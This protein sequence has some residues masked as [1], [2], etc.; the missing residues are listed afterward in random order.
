VSG[1]ERLTVANGLTALRVLLGGGLLYTILIGYERAALAILALGLLTELDGTVA[2]ATNTATE[3]GEQFDSAADAIFIGCGLLALV[4]IGKLAVLE[5]AILAGCLAFDPIGRLPNLRSHV[6]AAT[7]RKH[8]Q[9]ATGFLPGLLLLLALLNVPEFRTWVWV[10]IGLSVVRAAIKAWL[11]ARG[12]LR[13][14]FN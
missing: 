12:M 4:I 10:V 8:W 14:R 3:F 1:S 13:G 5:V 6:E 7:P 2:R 9:K 11:L